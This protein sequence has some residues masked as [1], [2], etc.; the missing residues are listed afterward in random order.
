M[1]SCNQPCLNSRGNSGRRE[2]NNREM[3]QR[4]RMQMENSPCEM[5]GREMS[6]RSREME[7][8][9]M[10]SRSREMEGREMSGRSREM[11]RREMPN[12]PCHMEW[13][14][15]EGISLAMAY[16]PWQRWGNLYQ[17]EEGFRCGTIFRDLDLPFTGRRMC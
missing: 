15:V 7:R 16:V 13:R 11:E 6:S 10:S 1:S 4:V 3:M 8:R 17:P 2:S 12:R 9:E 5:E 14:N